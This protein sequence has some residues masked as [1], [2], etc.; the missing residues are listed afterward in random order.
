MNLSTFIVIIFSIFLRLCWFVGE[1]YLQILAK[2]KKEKIIFRVKTRETLHMNA[3]K[4]KRFCEIFNYLPHW[5]AFT[6][7]AF[8]HTNYMK[9]KGRLASLIAICFFFLFSQ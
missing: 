3:G 5:H 8:V 4:T 7:N 6:Y 9:C 1:K 2:K